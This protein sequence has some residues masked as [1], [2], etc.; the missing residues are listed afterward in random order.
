MDLRPRIALRCGAVRVAAK[1]FEDGGVAQQEVQVVLQPG[2][3]EQVERLRMNEDAG[4]LHG[5]VNRCLREELVLNCAYKSS[6]LHNHPTRI[7][8]IQRVTL[9]VGNQPQVF[10]LVE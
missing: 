8:G 6:S 7:G 3:G 5:P 10:R 1:A 4:G 2:L 9:V